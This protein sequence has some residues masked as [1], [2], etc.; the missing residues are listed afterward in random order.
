M[1]LL[2]DIPVNKVKAF[3]T[4]FIE[5]LSLKHKDTLEELRK[6]NISNDITKVL[7]T[8]AAEIVIKYRA[9]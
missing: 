2:R 1:G 9:N 7:E 6:G 3:E 5:Y 4:D 8:A